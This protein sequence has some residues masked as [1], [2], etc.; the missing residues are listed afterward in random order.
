LSLVSVVLKCEGVLGEN[1]PSPVT[2][3]KKST[4]PKVPVTMG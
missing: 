1:Q 4:P 3:C 2:E